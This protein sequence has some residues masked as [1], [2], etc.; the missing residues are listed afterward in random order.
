MFGYHIKE[1]LNSFIDNKLREDIKDE[2]AKINDVPKYGE[3]KFETS[4]VMDWQRFSKA[5]KL[6]LTS[7]IEEIIT[8]PQ[9]MEKLKLYTVKFKKNNQG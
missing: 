2:F 5:I 7:N 1:I 8:N 6:M 4:E 9:D 3:L